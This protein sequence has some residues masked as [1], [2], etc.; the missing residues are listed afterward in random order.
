MGDLGD[1]LAG[2]RGINTCGAQEKFSCMHPYEPDTPSST[3]Q[4]VYIPKRL[5]SNQSRQRPGGD[6]KK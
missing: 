5:L 4:V 2:H 3:L 6:I 1:A